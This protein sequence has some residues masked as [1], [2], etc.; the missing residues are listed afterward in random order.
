MRIGAGIVAVFFL[1]VVW[2]ALQ[3]YPLGARSP[4]T[5]RQR[6]RGDHAPAFPGGHRWV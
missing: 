1:A 2:F 5:S 4:R 6:R 3:V